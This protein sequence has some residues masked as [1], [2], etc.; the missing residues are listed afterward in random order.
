M[1]AVTGVCGLFRNH[2]NEMTVALAMLLVVLFVAV[3]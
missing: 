3:V 1:T 2:I